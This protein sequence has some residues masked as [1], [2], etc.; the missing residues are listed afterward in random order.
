MD[1]RF[2]PAVFEPL[3][4]PVLTARG[5]IIDYVNQAARGLGLAPGLSRSELI[6]AGAELVHISGRSFQFSA[7]CQGELEI[8]YLTPVAWPVPP[9]LL[10][11]SATV[12]RQSMQTAMTSV[13]ALYDLLD[14]LEAEALRGLSGILQGLYQI[15]RVARNTEALQLLSSGGQS[16][17]RV[18]M[19]LLSY[20]E[21]LI[22]NAAELL[23]SAGLT[24]ESELSL[25][26]RNGLLDPSLAELAFWHLLSNAASYSAD[27]KIRLQLD[28]LADTLVLR[29]INRADP[30]S[31]PLLFGG[32]P[33]GEL[34]TMDRLGVGLQLVRSAAEAHG[35]SLLLS[36]ARDGTVTA[37][38]RLDVSG[39]KVDRLSEPI[40]LP[41]SG[42]DP[43][44]IALSQLLPLEAFDPRA[45]L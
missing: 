10:S 33:E 16:A 39:L 15:E 41:Q 28:C 27:R 26:S 8:L 1:E 3:P 42:L 14:P 6:P 40:R 30:E 5:G 44:R 23:R 32:I 9:A 43:G 13:E 11:R 38:L 37:L 18:P 34:R 36:A 21:E 4:Q 2:S 19:R 22:S 7:A 31:A 29:V 35:G 17:R 24:L 45:V 25:R 20:W 12:L